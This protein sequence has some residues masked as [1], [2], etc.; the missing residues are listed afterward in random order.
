MMPETLSLNSTATNGRVATLRFAKTDSLVTLA[1]VVAAD[2]EVVGA[3]VEASVLAEALAAVAP[4][5][6]ADLEAVVAS[7]EAS[8]DRLEDLASIPM[9]LQTLPT[10]SPT[11]LLP[12]VSPAT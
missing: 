3:L 12:V 4:S 10:L 11:S 8:V 2:S 7:A 5:A 1:S 6:A 9:V